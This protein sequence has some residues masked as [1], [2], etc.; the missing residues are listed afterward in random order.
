MIRLVLRHQRDDVDIYKLLL[1]DL[2]PVRPVVVFFI[3]PVE[4]VPEHEVL[5]EVLG[6]VAVVR[7]VRP[8]RVLEAPKPKLDVVGRVVQE[9]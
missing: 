1:C 8:R 6:R 7:L 4:L 3:R 5:R 9:R 2:L